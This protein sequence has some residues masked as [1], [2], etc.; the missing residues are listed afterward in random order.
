[1]LGYA[2]PFGSV[3]SPD[4]GVYYANLQVVNLGPTVVTINSISF[5]GPNVVVKFTTNLGSDTAASFSLTSASS[6]NGTYNP[7]VSTITALGSNQFQATTPYL[8]D[9]Q[10]FYR[11]VHN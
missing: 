9:A 10:Q 2:D 3:G 1:M 7:L 8:G 4:A 11:V 6:V 5:S